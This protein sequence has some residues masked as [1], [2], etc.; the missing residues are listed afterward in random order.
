VVGHV[1]KLD[2]SFLTDEEQSAYLEDH[3]ARIPKVQFTQEFS[4]S[5]QKLSSLVTSLLEFN[6]FFRGYAAD[7]IKSSLFDKVRKQDLELPF[8]STIRLEVDQPGVFTYKE[9]VEADGMDSHDFKKILIQE[10]KK[11]FNES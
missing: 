9:R 10:A 4:R 7:H 1:D 6:P 5:N 11:L 8:N 3:Q 2:Q